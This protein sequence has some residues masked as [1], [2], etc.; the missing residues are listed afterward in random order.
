MFR[1]WLRY[2]CRL[3][4]SK[5]H[6]KERQF[7]DWKKVVLKAGDGGNGCF[8]F[9]RKKF[10]PKAGPDGGDGGHGGSIV[11]ISDYSVKELA[12]LPKHIKAENGGAGRS[13]DCK[14]RNGSDCIFEVPL[15]TVVKEDGQV[16]ADMIAERQTFVAAHGGVG[17]FGNAH[18]KTALDRAPD[19]STDGTPGEEKVVELELK[20]IADIGLVGFPNAGKSTLLR[21]ISRAKP[22]VA[23]YPF[24]TINPFVGI[25]EFED[26]SQIADISEKDP[27][28]TFACLR[29]ELELFKDRLSQRPGA[30]VANKIDLVDWDD[31]IQGNAEAL[32]LPVIPVSAKN[33][34]GIPELK[35]KVRKLF[36]NSL[37]IF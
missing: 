30:I 19:M 27:L 17:G 26:Y 18:F 37:V 24:T 13:E 34:T 9:R 3:Y 22:A 5:A 10:E 7:I 12:H 16:I 8:H 11:L 36:N 15:G 20:T 21:A 32:S 14:G 28:T 23:A 4:S 29:E 25:M 31:E 1:G 33:G 35:A 2:I 6:S